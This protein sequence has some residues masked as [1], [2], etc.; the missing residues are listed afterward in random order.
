MLHTKLHYKE[1]GLSCKKRSLPWKTKMVLDI[2]KSLN[3]LLPRQ[4]PAECGDPFH[5][6]LDNYRE[7]Q[8]VLSHCSNSYW[9]ENNNSVVV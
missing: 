5:K 4:S 3:E 9:Q 7:R 2:L 8:N 1:N 6:E